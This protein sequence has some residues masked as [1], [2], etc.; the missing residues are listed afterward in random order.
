[1]ARKD[2]NTKV[3]IMAFLLAAVSLFFGIELP[4]GDVVVSTDFAILMVQ[5]DWSAYLIGLA[6]VVISLCAG[7]F[8]LN[9]REAANPKP[10]RL[11]VAA[12]CFL[13]V[14]IG[15]LSSLQF[16]VLPAQ[17]RFAIPERIHYFGL[18]FPALVLWLLVC[19][20]TSVLTLLGV[21]GIVDRVWLAS[22]L[23]TPAGLYALGWQEIGDPFT[24]DAFSHRSWPV[25]VV[26]SFSAAVGLSAWKLIAPGWIRWAASV[27]SL[28]IT[29][30]TLALVFRRPNPEDYRA[31]MIAFALLGVGEA[32]MAVRKTIQAERVAHAAFRAPSADIAPLA[33]ELWESRGRPEGSPDQDWQKAEAKLRARYSIGRLQPYLLSLILFLLAA[34]LFDALYLSVFGAGVDLVLGY[35]AWFLLVEFLSEGAVARVPAWALDLARGATEWCRPFFRKVR[36]RIFRAPSAS[37]AVTPDKPSTGAWHKTI[38]AA[39]WTLGAVVFFVAASEVLHY[40][41]VVIEPFAYSEGEKSDRAGDEL[42]KLLVSELSQIR[43]D[44]PELV[45]VSSKGGGASLNSGTSGNERPLANLAIASEGNS[46]ASAIPGSNELD[47]FGLKIPLG[48]LATLVQSPLRYV[49]RIEQI[50][51]SIYKETLDKKVHWR[52]VATSNRGKVWS[53]RLVPAEGTNDAPP[54]ADQEECD[55]STKAPRSPIQDLAHELAFLITID[56]PDSGMTRW[57]QA[58]EYFDHGVTLVNEFDR[59][60]RR[61]G[62]RAAIACFQNAISLDKGFS[63]AYD[64]LAAAYEKSGQP[65]RAAETL[66]AVPS[67][68]PNYVKA[69]LRRANAI[70]NTRSYY[71]TPPAIMPPVTWPPP[72]DEAVKIWLQ[73]AQEEPSATPLERTL[74]YLGL[75]QAVG[76]EEMR[77]L[78]DAYQ[79]H[80]PK[81]PGFALLSFDERAAQLAYTADAALRQMPRTMSYLPYYYC[82]RAEALQGAVSIS[83]R[84]DPDVRAVEYGLLNTLGVTV[85][86]HNQRK[87]QLRSEPAQPTSVGTWSRRVWA[88]LFGRRDATKRLAIDSI[89]LPSPA[90]DAVNGFYCYV[91]GAIDVSTLR[92]GSYL[93]LG[94]TN[95]VGRYA[96][97]YYAASLRLARDDPTIAC[98]Y[99]SASLYSTGNAAPMAALS[100]DPGQR[101][102]M[103]HVL[104]GL[105][106]DYAHRFRYDPSVETTTDAANT[107]A[108]E[109]SSELAFEYYKMAFDNYEASRNISPSSIVA[110]NDSAYCLWRWSLDARTG[111]FSGPDEKQI[112]ALV[113]E[114]RTALR[115]ISPKGDP[116][117]LT[118]LDTTLAELYLA[119]GKFADALQELE[120]LRARLGQTT[121]LTDIVNSIYL[122]ID[123]AHAYACASRV[124]SKTKD[125]Y[126]SKAEAALK[127][128]EE[129]EARSEFRPFSDRLDVI[130]LKALQELCFDAPKPGK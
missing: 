94:W 14:S 88:R 71:E 119:Q 107:A 91:E 30:A 67:D 59:T 98:N 112:A 90:L 3:G 19:L 58:F 26:V 40:G 122:F 65:L 10:S 64:R 114:A 54:P 50:T 52:A 48:S 124:D 77:Q 84:N 75:C 89:A 115:Y 49:L 12:V 82:K 72:A 20:S 47:L 121:P 81:G 116:A 22:F 97:P 28:F 13:G 76:D 110:V 117:A 43:K 27:F 9:T 53:T 1:M 41:N 15:V 106:H 123:S 4:T 108:D 5:G 45:V 126:Q 100:R 2:R 70:Y 93:A 130:N 37:P 129:M 7:L 44:I 99:A 57:G 73:V 51:G 103:G 39:L 113:R 96:I 68:K 34:S 18:W 11:F 111:G 86:L 105:A 69:L 63:G 62:L 102:A 66:R 125:A 118:A 92:S 61:A 128:I 120:S 42:A 127:T 29:G 95:P 17:S 31:A 6:V 56:Q 101:T 104:T 24:S 83:D 35:V 25:I 32:A 74:A 46:L 109:R 23:I 85:G 78:S 36:D 38:N 60:G 8:C 33:F 16:S 79:A 55:L 80:T 21:A 87:L